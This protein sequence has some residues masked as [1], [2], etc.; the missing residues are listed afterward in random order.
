MLFQKIGKILRGLTPNAKVNMAR[1]FSIKVV[2]CGW[3]LVLHAL[4][5]DL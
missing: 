4:K 1:F 2:Q 3:F 5:R